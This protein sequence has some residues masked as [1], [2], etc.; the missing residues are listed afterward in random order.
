MEIKQA[1]ANMG[2]DNFKLTVLLGRIITKYTEYLP[3]AKSFDRDQTAW[4]VQADQ[5][6]YFS[7]FPYLKVPFRVMSHNMHKSR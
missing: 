6:R 1:Q 4:T 7:Q 3:I 5:V 2:F